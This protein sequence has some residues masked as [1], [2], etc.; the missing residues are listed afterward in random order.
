MG[1]YTQ[2]SNSGEDEPISFSAGY[3]GKVSYGAHS[4]DGVRSG[5]EE[6]VQMCLLTTLAT[7]TT[8]AGDKKKSGHKKDICWQLASSTFT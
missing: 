1:K 3:G 5:L 6:G 2:T 8:T 4:P 7:N